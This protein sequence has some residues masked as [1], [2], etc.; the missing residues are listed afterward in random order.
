MTKKDYRSFIGMNHYEQNQILCNTLSI[1]IYVIFESLNSRLRV[2][3][4]NRA[5]IFR[6]FDVRYRYGLN[7]PVTQHFIYNYEHTIYRLILTYDI[8][9]G[10]GSV[11]FPVEN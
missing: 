4:E 8:N 2:Q 5:K 3:K 10:T 1:C 7:T 6:W 11:Y 9:H